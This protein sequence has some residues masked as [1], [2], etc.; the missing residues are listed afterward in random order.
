VRDGFADHFCRK[1]AVAGPLHL[2]DGASMRQRMGGA[3]SAQPGLRVGLVE[4]EVL[5][6]A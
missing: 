3:V 4:W 6:Y 1:S 5:R 2:T